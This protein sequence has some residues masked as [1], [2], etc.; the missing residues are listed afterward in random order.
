[1]SGRVCI[2]DADL[3]SPSLHDHFR[4]ENSAGLAE[5]MKNSAPLESFVRAAWNH[6]LWF[7]SAGAINGDPTS[8]VNAA[9]LRARISELR[10]AFDYVLVDAPPVGECG[11]GALLAQMTDGVVLVVGCNSTRRETAKAVKG[12]LEAAGVPILGTVLNKRTYPI[13]E[14]LYRRL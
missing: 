4:V 2:V 5:A 11:D 7:V 6:R 1:M 8:G 3:R 10:A 12:S 14:A 13:P 9:R